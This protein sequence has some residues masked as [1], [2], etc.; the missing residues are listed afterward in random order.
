MFLTKCEYKTA[1]IANG[2]EYKFYTFNSPLSCHNI[3]EEASTDL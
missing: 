1:N 3:F 2:A